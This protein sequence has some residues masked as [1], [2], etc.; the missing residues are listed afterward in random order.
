MPGAATPTVLHGKFSSWL[1]WHQPFLHD[2]LQGLDASFRN[3]VVC[4]RVENEARFPRADLVCLKS[5]ALLQPAAAALCA[6]ELRARFAPA[7]L[8][9]HFGWS[10]VRLL[11]LKALLRVPLVT[12]FGGRDAGVQLR[13]PKSAPVY[14]ILLAASDRVVCVSAH[15]R[16]AVLAAGAAEE[17]TLVVH[18][19]TD[20][21]R[22]PFSERAG[23]GA[24]PLR[25]LM[26]GRL[27]EKKGHGD[28]LAALR[29]LRDAG[30][31]AEL[32][33]VGA[34]PA[35]GAILAEAARLGLGG[36]VELAEPTDQGRL[37]ARF[38]AADVFLHC[39]V[40]ARDGDVEGIPNV[41]VEAAATGLPVV[42]TRH[43]GIGEAVEDGEGGLLVAEGEPAALAA[44][45]E[46]LAREPELRLAL[47]RGAAA[48]VRR[49]FDLAVQVGAHAALYREL[50]AEGAPRPV[51]LPDDFF[52]L[53]RRAVGGGARS[54]DHAQA[55]AVAALLPGLAPLERCLGAAPRGG[56]DRALEAPTAWPRP[57]RSAAELAIDLA[58]R[59]PLPALRAS[60]A[61][62]R[63]R[64][65]A[66]DRAVLAHLAAGGPLGDAPAAALERPLRD[67][68]GEPPPTTPW[69]R[70]RA[71]LAGA[72]AANEDGDGLK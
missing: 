41:V 1:P 66:L 2:L 33:I 45:L 56:L 27:V 71:R 68:R 26:V 67:L 18:R 40:T 15:L 62:S 55:Q 42:A 19:G 20:L 61:R 70:L 6:A 7:L 22:F 72:D 12:S 34:G 60:Q 64:A 23:R 13:D 24:G 47:G 58:G 16:E 28:A 51:A 54:W 30:C 14:R 29:R 59:A 36:Q 25:I 57:W 21:A 46:R 3:V 32:A 65:A 39:S 10:G 52:A 11:L 63:A 43:G 53:A 48:R 44:A 5:R 69:R 9:G 35:R 17:R 8:H 38:A 31:A 50:I 4:N 37:C 49:D